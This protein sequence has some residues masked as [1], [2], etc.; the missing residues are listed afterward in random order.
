MSKIIEFRRV[1]TGERLAERE[2]RERAASGPFFRVEFWEQAPNVQ[3][4]R[5]KLDGDMAEVIMPAR[6]WYVRLWRRFFPLTFIEERPT[7]GSL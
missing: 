7:E 6:P 5:E 3:Q 4:L 2:A 1:L